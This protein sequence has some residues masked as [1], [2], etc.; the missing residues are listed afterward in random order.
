M[1]QTANFHGSDIDAVGEHYG[2]DPSDIINYSGNV[3]PMGIP[4][5]VHHALIN[6]IGVIGEY[7][8]RDYHHLLLA[9]STYTGLPTDRLLLGSGSTELI[10]HFIHYVHPSHAMVIGPTYSEYKSELNK[11]GAEVTTYRL[12]K[13]T[14]F[15]L[16]IPTLIQSLHDETKLIILCNP[17]NPTSSFVPTADLRDLLDYCESKGIFVMIDETYIEFYTLKVDQ[18]AFSLVNEYTCLFVIRGVSKFYGLPGIRL[19]YAGSSHPHVL[20]AFSDEEKPWSVNSIAD[21]C[22]RFIFFD[23]AFIQE[24]TTFIHKEKERIQKTLSSIS[25]LRLYPSYTNFFIVEILEPSIDSDQL[26]EH[27]IKQQMMIRSLSHYDGIGNRF[28]RFCIMDESANTQLLDALS[29]L[30]A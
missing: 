7:P 5:M 29:H 20:T 4:P 10:S 16:H 14:H 26:F 9:L 21:Y 24:S 17:N 8:E 3:N 25:A 28:F 18:S 30:F 6:H 2:I 19:G 12:T 15:T 27:L 13:D 11:V 22:G 1:S 23:T